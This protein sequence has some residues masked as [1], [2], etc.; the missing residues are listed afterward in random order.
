MPTQP[1]PFKVLQ[2]FLPENTFE[3]V[4]EY[5]RLYPLHLSITRERK[6]VMGD[7]RP[8]ATG[9]NR[10]RISINGNLNPYSFL[11]TLLHEIA[12]LYAF[13]Q[14][15]HKIMPHGEEWKNIFKKL[16]ADFLHNQVFPK[17]V[18]DALQRYLH[19]MKASTCTDPHLYKVLKKYDDDTKG[20]LFLDEVPFGK[21]FATLDGRTFQK[22]EKL[23]TRYKCKE[24]KT[25]HTYLI[26]SIVEVKLI[27][28]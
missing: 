17:D 9:E 1:K 7:Y 19:Q 10:H 27:E 5:M 11:I 14:Y 18:A 24:I 25:G 22:T 20:L 26:P 28:E 16:L 8:P 21:P 13:T 15:Q 4:A 6:S 3:K 23:R 2:N 12:H